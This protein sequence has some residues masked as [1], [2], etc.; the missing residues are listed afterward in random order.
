MSNM[1]DFSTGDCHRDIGEYRQCCESSGCSRN[2]VEATVEECHCQGEQTFS[3]FNVYFS[4]NEINK[5]YDRKTGKYV[6]SFYQQSYSHARKKLTSLR[7]SL[8]EEIHKWNPYSM[9]FN[10]KIDLLLTP[11]PPFYLCSGKINST[12]LYKDKPSVLGG[13][14]WCSL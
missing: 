7:R 4:L 5:S 13:D 12:A 3:H 8:T 1:K 2:V 10:S 6:V 14:I 11:L 9:E